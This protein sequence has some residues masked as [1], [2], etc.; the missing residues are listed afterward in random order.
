MCWQP[1]SVLGKKEIKWL[2]VSLI[3]YISVV[4]PGM[5]NFNSWERYYM[6]ILEIGY[7]YNNLFYKLAKVSEGINSA[8]EI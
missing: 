1:W 7:Q 6:Y 5:Y 4:C 3:I 8:S 2:I